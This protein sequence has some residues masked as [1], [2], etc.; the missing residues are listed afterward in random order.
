MGSTNPIA[1]ITNNLG[2]DVNIYDVFNPTASTTMQGPL[3]YTKLATVSNGASAQVQTVHF[4][5]QLQAMRTG[6]ITALNNNYYLQFPV[7]VLAVS[8]FADSNAFT[9]TSDMQQGMEDSFKFIKYTLANPSSQLATN[10]RTALGDKTSQKDAVNKFFQA[11]ASFKK[12]T[13]TTWTAVFSWQAQ[14]T[15]P[16]QGT[17]YLYSLGSSSTGSTTSSSAPALVATLVIVASAQADSAVLTMAGTNNENT[18]VVMGGDGTMQEQNQGTGN[19][20]VVLT[21]T[22]LNITQTSQQ[23]GKTV[24]NYAIGAA[25]TGTIN[26]E[27]VSGNLNQL[28]IPDPSDTSS[29]AK[30]K[31]SANSFS[32][33]TFT[34]I[35]GMLTGI[36]MLFYMAKGHKQA[37]TQKKNDA[38]KDAKDKPDAEKKQEQVEEKYQE[39]DVPVQ[40]ARSVELES[41]VVPEVQG[42]YRQLGQA[43]EIQIN[44]ATVARQESEL[45]DVMEIAPPSPPTEVTAENLAKVKT[46]LRK[47]MD[48]NSS[49]TDRDA[50][51]TEATTKL[52][53][54]AK[55]LETTLADPSSNL[56]QE[57]EVALSNTKEA[58]EQAG[59]QTEALKEN[60]KGKEKGIENDQE[61]DLDETELEE[62]QVED[63]VEFVGK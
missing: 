42:G 53:D 15:N 7:A 10:F 44:Q 16:W 37:E 33:S 49:A 31:N 59:E 4:A 1:T 14:F 30:D 54:T 19:L 5:S 35:V 46:D 11:T 32:I 45:R 43:Q 38:Q 41:S 34:Q 3:T 50:A 51:M 62:P 24:T 8:P 58:I 29:N 25:F 39:E 6:S 28:A 40:R 56:A 36:G 20:S 60:Q 9:L 61:K 47:A 2:Y 12:C 48:A 63:P 23:D 17:Y 26:G 18:S 52:T 21:P 57:E 27:K 22:W 13:L 55:E